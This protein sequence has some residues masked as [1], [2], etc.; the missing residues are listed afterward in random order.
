MD[1]RVEHFLCA[2]GSTGNALYDFIIL[3]AGMLRDVVDDGLLQLTQCIICHLLSRPCQV[4]KLR[5][6]RPRACGE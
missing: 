2:I 3:T 6:E 5:S 1:E 4:E